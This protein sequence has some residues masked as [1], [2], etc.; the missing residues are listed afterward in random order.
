[1][2]Y[3][4]SAR[5]FFD[6]FEVVAPLEADLT[7]TWTDFSSNEGKYRIQFPGTPLQWSVPLELRPP[8]TLY[9]TAYASS[10]QYSVMYFDY[11]ETP[12]P[13]DSAAL[14]SFLDDLRDGQKDKQEQM[15]GKLT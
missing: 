5:S 6:S 13:T 7:A 11:A 9:Q 8:S 10:G 2:N 4:N 1:K 3:D 15:G 12:T 14:K